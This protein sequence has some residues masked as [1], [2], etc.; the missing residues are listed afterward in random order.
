M[1]KR[2]VKNLLDRALSDVSA[3]DFFLAG[4]IQANRQVSGARHAALL[5]DLRRQ[6]DARSAL[7]A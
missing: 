3:E 6:R 7:A 2:L 5:A 1:S 4:P